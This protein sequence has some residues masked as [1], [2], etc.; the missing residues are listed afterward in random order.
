MLSGGRRR[1]GK[2][3]SIFEAIRF[4]VIREIMKLSNNKLTLAQLQ[5]L[6]LVA[7]TSLDKKLKREAK[8]KGDVK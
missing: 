4:S 6:D 8:G 5:R 7:L 1:K 2:R 3:M